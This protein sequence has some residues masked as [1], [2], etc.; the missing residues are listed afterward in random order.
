ML[1]A[2]L[3]SL[4][5]MGARIALAVPSPDADPEM[6]A[7]DPINTILSLVM[8][9]FGL[10]HALRYP[11][12]TLVILLRAWPFALA[13]AVAAA[14]AMWSQSP[15]H[16]LRRALSLATLLLFAAAIWNKLGL[17]RFMRV[18][19]GTTIFACI[20]SLGE[21]V[22]R[23]EIGFDIGEYAD[24]IRGIF[25][26]KNGF[27]LALLGGTV[28]LAF[29]AL[30]RRRLRGKDIAVALFFLIMLV[31][32]RST[33]ALL[34]S[35]A[36]MGGTF[37]ALGLDRGGAWRA[38]ILIL[39]AGGV[40]LALLILTLLGSS[41]VFEAIGKDDTLTG[42]VYI[43]A[44]VYEAIGLR[45]YLGYGYNAFWLQGTNPAEVIWQRIGWLAPTAHSGYLD[46]AL[47]LGMLGVAVV[48]MA[49]FLVLSRAGM[50]IFDGRRPQAFWVLMVSATY[51]V[52]NYSESLL[53]R[54]DLQFLLWM[55]ASLAVAPVMRR[56]GAESWVGPWSFRSARRPH[57]AKSPAQKTLP[58]PAR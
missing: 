41:G 40:T 6:G 15:E 2:A 13:V 17:R 54:P 25:W 56:Q 9:G 12:A 46:V 21:A 47:Q 58:V 8:L 39:T 27:G 37:V 1:F 35:V 24:A 18:L 50:A 14:S 31:L 36:V 42:R 28:A 7:F 11:Q 33:T 4:L 45:R 3:G 52:Y 49:H 38:A 43:W 48:V 22:I 23:P 34:L 30:D 20:A 10:F 44:E 57:A 26:Q 29:V 51:L 19:V 16:S 53:L 55:M 5:Y 32:S